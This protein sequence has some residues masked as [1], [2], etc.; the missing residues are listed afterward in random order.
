[1]PS[2]QPSGEFVYR[3]EP[4]PPA[5]PGVLGEASLGLPELLALSDTRLL[6]L[7]RASVR[8]DGVYTNTIRVFEVD[9]AGAVERSSGP[10][11]PSRWPSAW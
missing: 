4:V 2:G 9:L 7:E 5:A 10:R 6:V 1:V 8:V 11:R 3:T